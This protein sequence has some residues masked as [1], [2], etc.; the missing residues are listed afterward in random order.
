MDILANTATPGSAS[1]DAEDRTSLECLVSSRSQIGV[2]RR[3]RASFSFTASAATLTTLAR[4][5]NNNTFWPVW[6]AQ[7]VAGIS[8]YS[9]AYEAPPT[10]W[11]GTSMA[12]QDRA[13]NISEHL[14]GEPDLKSGPVV[15]VCH[16]LGGLIVK[17]IMLDLQQ[18]KE[19]RPEA[20][21]LLGLVREI[22]FAATPHTGSRHATL[23]DRLR[24]LAWPS[25]VARTFVAND[26]TLRSINVAYRGLAEERRGALAHRV[27]YETQ[28][29]PLGVIVDEASSDPGLPGD[30]PIPIDANHITIVKPADRS[31]LLYAR[32]RDFVA[33]LPASAEQ[34]GLLEIQ[35]LPDLKL[36]LPLN[37]IP[38]LIRLAIIGLVLLIGYKG[39]QQVIAPIDQRAVVEKIEEAKQEQLSA[40][41]KVRIEVAREK[42]VP[43]EKLAPLFENL[44][45][46]NLTPDQMREKADEAIKAIVGR[47]NQKLEP[48]KEGPDI[49]QTIRAARAKLTNLDTAGAQAI[50]NTKI[51]QEEESRKQRLIPL[52]AEKAAVARLS[53]DYPTTKATL[54]E[55][56]RLDPNRVWSWID[57]GDIWMTTGSLYEA[58]K[59]FRAAAVAA[60]K[61]KDEGDLA[62]SYERLGDVRSAQG[63]LPDALKS[64]ATASPSPSV[65][66][67]RTRATPD[68]S[69]ICGCP[70]TRSA[71]FTS[72][73]A[74]CPAR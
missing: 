46:L 38:K 56:L 16:S 9:L 25:S 19:R 53:Y 10:N 2:G 61:T 67:R 12:L 4:A 58:A 69:A 28:D 59:A 45:M 36:E 18:Q 24:F 27:F 31:S 51:A 7:D 52:L 49:D 47:A 42:G 66:P 13:V 68:G 33:K 29:T 37:P 21:D 62:A 15:F 11:L 74:L 5:P 63:A 30:P 34:A 71:M 17:Q 23:L 54:Q 40:F 48:S 72:R 43:P 8:V 73:R 44:G 65:W 3:G 57:L 39:V 14:F 60:L 35:A 64:I 20:A 32:T 22:V 6:L 1:A 55:L 26:P 70:T 41:D 50:L